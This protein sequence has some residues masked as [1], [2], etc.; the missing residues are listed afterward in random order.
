VCLCVQMICNI[1]C[2]MTTVFYSVKI[3]YICV[4]MSVSTS[5]CLCD[6]SYVSMECMYI[7]VSKKDCTFFKNFYFFGPLM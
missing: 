1:V 6:S 3:V 4:F 2:K 7:Q 5:Y